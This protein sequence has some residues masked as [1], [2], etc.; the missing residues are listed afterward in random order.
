MEVELEDLDTN[1]KDE[2][3]EKL[4]VDVAD[5]EDAWDILLLEDD[6]D[7]KSDFEMELDNN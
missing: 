7:Y 6:D 5:N 1:N 2:I 3:E 4:G